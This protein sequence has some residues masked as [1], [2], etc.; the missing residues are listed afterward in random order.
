MP[1]RGCEEGGVE[2][3]RGARARERRG[4]GT[5]AL[6]LA[7]AATHLCRPS[8]HR[9]PDARTDHACLAETLLALFS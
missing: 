7:L 5:L 4:T 6:A 1:V 3:A 2:G 9:I 8:L